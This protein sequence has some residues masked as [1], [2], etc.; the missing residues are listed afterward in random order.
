MLLVMLC[1]PRVKGHRAAAVSTPESRP[2]SSLVDGVRR[3]V[4][5]KTVAA[6]RRPLT[7][8]CM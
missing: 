8:D 7:M 2:S 4:W 3:V 5:R 6:E 1:E